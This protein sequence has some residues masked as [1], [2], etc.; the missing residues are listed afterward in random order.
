MLSYKGSELEVVPSDMIDSFGVIEIFLFRHG[1]CK[2]NATFRTSRKFTNLSYKMTYMLCLKLGRWILGLRLAV[3]NPAF[4]P[5][6]WLAR[7]RPV[8]NQV[9]QGKF[10][11][12]QFKTNQK[13]FFISLN[14]VSHLLI[15]LA[16]KNKMIFGNTQRWPHTP[17]AILLSVPWVRGSKLG[18]QKKNYFSCFRSGFGALSC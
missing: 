4:T 8:V 14:S 16:R 5:L 17:R 1:W 18:L 9:F 12:R 15:Y 3:L 13:I 10:F 6:H 2:S 11:Y 7:F